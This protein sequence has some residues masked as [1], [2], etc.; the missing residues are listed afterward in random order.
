MAA[1]FVVAIRAILSLNT[2]NVKNKNQFQSH[3]SFVFLS[4]LVLEARYFH[5][6]GIDVSEGVH[7]FSNLFSS[8]QLVLIPRTVYKPST[9][10]CL[11]SHKRDIENSVDQY[12]ATRQDV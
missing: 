3:S 2:F 1:S 8:Q 6:G 9:H 12:Q 11:A 4:E 5:S 10:L 7:S